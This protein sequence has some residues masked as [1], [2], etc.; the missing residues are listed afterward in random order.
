MVSISNN[1]NLI[2]FIY[3]LIKQN[4]IQNNSIS[5][6]EKVIRYVLIKIYI[7]KLTI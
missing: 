2:R 5:I 3:D 1:E 4:N 6:N 7:K